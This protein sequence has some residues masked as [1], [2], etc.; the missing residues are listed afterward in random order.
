M[1]GTESKSNTLGGEVRKIGGQE[2]SLSGGNGE[3]CGVEV[4]VGDNG[5]HYGD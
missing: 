4:G 2:L 5:N 3:V 1:G